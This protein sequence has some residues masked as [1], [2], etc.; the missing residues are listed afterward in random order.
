MNASVGI[1]VSMSA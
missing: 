1:T